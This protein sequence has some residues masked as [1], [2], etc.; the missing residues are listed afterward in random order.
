MATL[1]EEPIGRFFRRIE[2]DRDFFQY[3]NLSETAAM[4][5]AT[6]RANNYLWNAIDKMMIDGMPDVDFCDYDDK[7]A[8]FNFDLTTREI[9]I[10]SSLMYEFYL[11]KDI[12]K[13][14]TYTVNYTHVDLKVFDPSGARKTFK[15]LYDGVV[16]ENKRLLDQ[17]R[18]TDRLTGKYKTIDYASYDEG[19]E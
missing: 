7:I 5:L 15:S 8:A 12:S 3:N 19:D 1:F 13:L 4:Q 11:E 18:N 14:K 10:L 2:E 16:D 17:Y 9:F 6:T